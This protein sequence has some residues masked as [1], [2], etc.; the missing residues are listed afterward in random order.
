MRME[1]EGYDK[2]KKEKLAGRKDKR[3]RSFCIRKIKTMN[4]EHKQNKKTLKL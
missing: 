3:L 1:T 2:K 4:D